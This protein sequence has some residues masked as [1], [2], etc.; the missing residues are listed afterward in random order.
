MVSIIQKDDDPKSVLRGTAGEVA[1]SDFGSPK[2]KKILATMKTA[3]LSQ[4]DAVAI[5]APQ[6]G[7]PLRIFVVSKRVFEHL[8]KD[9]ACDLVFINPVLSKLSRKK[10]VSDEGCLSIRPLYGLVERSLKATIRAYN[11]NGEPFTLGASGL[12]AQIFQHETDH[13]NGILFTDKALKTWEYVPES[14][15]EKKGAA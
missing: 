13:L 9:N 11:E 7:V 2:L 6:I 14:T 12:L 1:D 8:K 5:A 10:K 3:I 15:R 4:S